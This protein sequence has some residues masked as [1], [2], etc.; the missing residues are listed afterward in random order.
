MPEKVKAFKLFLNSLAER[1]IN[2]GCQR[3][4]PHIKTG[5]ERT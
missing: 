3:M 4:P 5:T 1:D 2:F